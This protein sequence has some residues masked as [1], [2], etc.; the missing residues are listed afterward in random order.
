[1]SAE[2]TGISVV[3][4]DADG[5]PYIEFNPNLLK[6]MGWD[7]QTLLEWEIIGKMAIIRKKDDGNNIL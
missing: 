4:E 3:K 5:E 1:M 7:D 6:Q 2:I